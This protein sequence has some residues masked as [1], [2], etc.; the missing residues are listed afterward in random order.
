M[1]DLAAAGDVGNLDVVVALRDLVRG[2]RELEHRPR[3]ATRHV[4]RK[5]H[6]HEQAG[7]QRQPQALEQRRNTC[8]QLILRLRDDDGAPEAPAEV[9]RPGDR[10]VRPAGAG[11][12]ELELR[13][14]R[15]A[16]LVEVDDAG[17]EQARQCRVEEPARRLARALRREEQL[18]PA[19]ARDVVDAVARR[20]LELPSRRR[21][22]LSGRD[23]GVEPR[24][25]ARLA[26]QLPARPVEGVRLEQL[27]RNRGR[28]E[29]G[30]DHADEEQNRKL[31]AK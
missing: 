7:E 27:E 8:R 24:D 11:R 16:Q 19:D 29:A 18:Q 30:R 31:D 5:Q 10:E 20:L 22:V 6:R 21:V 23:R 4:H 15:L 12:L 17:G 9:E 28:D 3:E 2:V 13:L 25:A 26:A 14:A 1:P